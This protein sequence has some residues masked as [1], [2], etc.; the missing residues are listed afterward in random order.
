MMIANLNAASMKQSET[1]AENYKNSMVYISNKYASRR[2]FR[3]PAT[4]QVSR[5]ALL[6]QL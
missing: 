4:D 1:L 6:L 5:L 3:L 2:Y